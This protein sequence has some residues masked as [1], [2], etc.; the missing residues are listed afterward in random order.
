MHLISE[1]VTVR[2]VR[3]AECVQLFDL[4]PSF[5]DGFMTLC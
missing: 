5:A 4:S 1:S 2:V 3:Y